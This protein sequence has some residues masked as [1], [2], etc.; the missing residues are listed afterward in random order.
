MNS[1]S[2][3]EKVDEQ[4][5]VAV[6]FTEFGKV[7]LKSFYWRGKLFRINTVEMVNQLYM[8][9]D[10]VHQVSVSNQLGAFKLWFHTSTLDWW[11]KEVYWS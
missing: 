6:V 5:S 8:G 1:Q 3:Y 10:L 11:L 2:N 4:I 9:E 7:K